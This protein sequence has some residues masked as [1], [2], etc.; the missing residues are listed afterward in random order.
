MSD[1][2]NHTKSL[3][4]D[5][6]KA[7]LEEVIRLRE[8]NISLRSELATLR[9][10]MTRMELEMDRRIQSEVKQMEAFFDARLRE[11]Q[12]ERKEHDKDHDKRIDALEKK[13]IQEKA[14]AGGLGALAGAGS[15]GA[16][17]GLLKFLGIV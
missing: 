10:E 13:E 8:D 9:G 5:F 17:W 4:K 7:S 6:Q 14:K 15:G 16:I 2:G 1:S 11:H 3:L 12:A